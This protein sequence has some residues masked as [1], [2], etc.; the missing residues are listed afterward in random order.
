MLGAGLVPMAGDLNDM[1]RATMAQ[2]MEMEQKRREYIMR[3]KALDALN[4]EQ[5]S[6]S[7]EGLTLAQLMSLHEMKRRELNKQMNGWFYNQAITAGGG[8]IGKMAN[9][10]T[11]NRIVDR[12][13]NMSRLGPNITKMKAQTWWKLAL[14]EITSDSVLGGRPGWAI[15]AMLGM[16]GVMAAQEGMDD[17][18][19]TEVLRRQQLDTIRARQ[20]EVDSQRRGSEK[21]SNQPLAIEEGDDEPSPRSFAREPVDAKLPA[22]SPAMAGK[23]RRVRFADE[24][25]LPL[26]Q[27]QAQQ[28]HQM[29][30]MQS[31]QAQQ[32]QQMPTQAQ[33]GQSQQ[34]LTPAPPRTAA[35]AKIQSMLSR[36]GPP[37]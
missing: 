32:A 12:Y 31:Q 35:D 6:M 1:Q 17:F 36:A 24:Q 3:I 4:G 11:G 37:F 33:M 15:I 29:Q 5:T 14:E 8:F 2:V 25:G 22:A 16:T 30:Q 27:T 18:D 7:V 20:L 21:N 34:V 26:A 13:F 10:K 19:A 28:A 9:G 23:Q